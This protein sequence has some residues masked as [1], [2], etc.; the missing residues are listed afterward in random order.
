MKKVYI[1]TMTAYS[2][3]AQITT[4][5]NSYVYKTRDMARVQLLDY[6]SQ[7]QTQERYILTEQTPNY[8]TFTVKSQQGD[9]QLTLSVDPLGVV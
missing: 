9:Y 4:N 1:L 5:P 2:E 7:L 3:T 8:A 6:I